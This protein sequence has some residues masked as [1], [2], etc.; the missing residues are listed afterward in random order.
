MLT[1]MTSWL[2]LS[3]IFG[4]S[5]GLSNN[6][7]ILTP[8]VFRCNETE[9]ILVHSF[10]SQRT[11]LKLQ[12]KAE[13]DGKVINE[14]EKVTFTEKKKQFQLGV[15][16]DHCF[17]D[18]VY[19][20]IT[21]YQ[22]E[23]NF[24]EINNDECL[25]ILIGT[26]I[27]YKIPVQKNVGYIF[28]Q[29]DLP[30]YLPKQTVQIRI[31]RLNENMYPMNMSVK[32]VIKDPSNSVV[33]SQ[34][35]NDKADI[36]STSFKLNDNSQT[37]AWII[38]VKYTGK[39]VL[40][41]T[42]IRFLVQEYVMPKF[43]IHIDVQP[44]LISKSTKFMNISISAMHFYNKTIEGKVYLQYGNNGDKISGKLENGQYFKQVE[45]KG[46]HCGAFH[47]NA[48]VIEK[49]TRMTE[50]K[51][52]STANFINSNISAEEKN[53]YE[54]KPKHE[55][56]LKK[57]SDKEYYTTGDLIEVTAEN[58]N[59]I[60]YCIIGRGRILNCG[61]E[62]KYSEST[63]A[64]ITFFLDENMIPVAELIT[65]CF[66]QK[67]IN[68]TASLSFK[69][70]DICSQKKQLQV[71]ILPKKKFYSPKEKIVIQMK[72]SQ[73]QTIGLSL[74]DDAVHVISNR[75]RLTTDFVR[76]KMLSHNLESFAS[77]QKQ[78]KFKFSHAGYNIHEV[79]PGKKEALIV[80]DKASPT[81]QHDL[82]GDIEVSDKYHVPKAL[83]QRSDLEGQKIYNNFPASKLFKSYSLRH[84][85]VLNETLILPDSL[86]RWRFQAI[87][88]SK[89]SPFCVYEPPP[90]ITFKY[91]VPEL[92]TPKYVKKYGMFEVKFIL[93]NYGHKAVM[94]K[95]TL[96]KTKY[97]CLK[98]NVM[99]VNVPSLNSKVTKF[100]AYT[101][102]T[103]NV[104]IS[105]TIEYYQDPD[106]NIRET[107]EKIIFVQDHEVSNA[108]ILTFFLEKTDDFEDS[109][110]TGM[111]CNERSVLG[112]IV[113]TTLQE[114]EKLM[115][116]SHGSGNQNIIYMAMS[117]YV[118]KYILNTKQMNQE[119]YNNG[120]K[121]IRMGIEKQ[122]FFQK[123]DGSYSTYDDT[124]SSIW[125][126]AFVLKIFCQ[127]SEFEEIDEGLTRQT[128]FWLLKQQNLD[129]H[130][131]DTS[132][133][134]S[135]I[136]GGRSVLELTAFVL[137]S[138]MECRQIHAKEIFENERR[139]ISS[140][141]YL[142]KN[143]DTINDR[144][145][146]AITTYALTLTISSKRIAAWGKMTSMVQPWKEVN[147]LEKPS[148]E[149][150][151]IASYALLTQLQ[152]DNITT[153]FQIFNWLIQQKDK[154]GMFSSTQNTVIALQALA[155]YS[156]KWNAPDLNLKIMQLTKNY[157]MQ[158]DATINKT[159]FFKKTN[160]SVDATENQIKITSIGVRSTYVQVLTDF[161]IFN[162]KQKN[163]HFTIIYS[164]GK[165]TPQINSSH[166]LN[167]TLKYNGTS[168]IQTP[169]M[170]LDLL[171]GYYMKNNVLKMMESLSY[172]N[173]IEKNG[174]SALTFFL[175]KLEPG[176]EID[177]NLTLQRGNEKSLTPSSIKIYNYDKPD[178]SCVILY[179]KEKYFEL[180]CDSNICMCPEGCFRKTHLKIEEMWNIF[181]KPDQVGISVKILNETMS[182]LTEQKQSR[183]IYSG[184]ID[185][186]FTRDAGIIEEDRMVDVI[187]DRK[188]STSSLT[189]EERYII[190]TNKYR[191]NDTARYKYW[192]DD[193]GFALRYNNENVKK[194]IKEFINQIKVLAKNACQYVI[195]NV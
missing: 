158:S 112:D 42:N 10:T 180:F 16:N 161:N 68:S 49:N 73:D 28:I 62:Y 138:L 67:I 52:D 159:S 178:E 48:K 23:N 45:I 35:F 70:L 150:V 118:L 76:R 172:I 94:A 184:K 153:A 87:S 104:S 71:Q 152:Y 167:I 127:A 34:I 72:G 128:M 63:P 54:R 8:N 2:L 142:E 194:Q 160:P 98:K 33:K 146:L 88:L 41:E 144:L 95:V 11:C 168:T 53:V 166:Y 79:Q 19:L 126:T 101:M 108:K 123:N 29:T 117:V 74:V 81:H 84:D 89:N 39:E 17:N 75:Y 125:L 100:L 5:Q 187:I 3:I 43:E 103:G 107:I 154:N 55:L 30:I 105:V 165:K 31:F 24:S 176:E 64:K 90:I 140:M 177:L 120:T 175:E 173:K 121:F 56:Y 137:I 37:G 27:E 38:S 162:T 189:K 7:W 186:I 169:V 15:F 21:T 65:Y 163:C 61:K 136:M 106:G 111:T 171:S 25:D 133:L 143:L 115:Q 92:H 179:P 85:E 1:G 14:T 191:Q 96:D 83:P 4:F 135:D 148:S 12:L 164:M 36:I 77:L 151:L 9:I 122:K 188:C 156:I 47:I 13:I 59:Q 147:S 145:T 102:Y 66:K 51:T 190:V 182:N 78:H 149:S 183:I 57:I 69:V 26:K 50:Y 141:K 22:S 155:E 97:I 99:E 181:C 6:S 170:E 46:E 91:I 109:A 114:P 131:E 32:M 124:R 193:Y 80:L 139:I 18:Y 44:K 129:G 185:K 132:Y 130:F 110:V 134:N 20:Y 93:Y 40:K 86:T 192:I 157:D 174:E 60:H 119:I 58:C 113:K 116:K 195:D 82:E